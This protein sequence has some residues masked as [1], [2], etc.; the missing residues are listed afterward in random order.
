MKI[1]LALLNFLSPFIVI[2]ESTYCDRGS[3]QKKKRETNKQTE[4][5]RERK[6]ER[7]RSRGR[8]RGREIER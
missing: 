4:R 7:A 3:K 5:E 1:I 2:Q 6:R 8:N